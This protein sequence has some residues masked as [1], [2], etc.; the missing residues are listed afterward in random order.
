MK[1]KYIKQI[2]FWKSPEEL[3]PDNLAIYSSQDFIFMCMNVLPV[4]RSMCH[5]CTMP[6]E[7]RIEHSI[8]LDWSYR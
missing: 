1:K 8:P 3:T 2:K 7:A 6:A 5:V 4:F